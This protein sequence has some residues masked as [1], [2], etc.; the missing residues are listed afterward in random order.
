[1][2]CVTALP[3]VPVARAAEADVIKCFIYIWIIEIKPTKHGNIYNRASG[4]CGYMFR[5]GA[6]SPRARGRV[7]GS[8]EA[9]VSYLR[10]CLAYLSQDLAS[11]GEYE[12]SRDVV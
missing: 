2:Q 9:Y 5:A 12:D 3:V 10:G 4:L 6:P 7:A 11:C 1:M 8:H